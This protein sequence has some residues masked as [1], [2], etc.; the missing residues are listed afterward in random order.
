M[1]QINTYTVTYNYTENGGTAATKTSASVNYGSTIDLTPTA[2]KSGYTFVGW[3]TNKNGTSKLSSLTMGTSNVTLYAIYSKTVT[4]TCYYYSG[5]AQTSKKVSGTMYNKST[6]ASINLGTTTLTGYTFRG[7]STSNSGNAT[8]AVASN[9][10]ASLSADATYYACYSYTVTGTYKYYN[11]TA[12]TSSTA[13]ATAYMNSSG[14]K[15]G[16]KPTAPTVSNPSG[17]TARGWSKSSESNVESIIVPGTITENITYYYS[18]KKD[19]VG[20]YYYYNGSSFTTSTSTVTAYMS[21]TGSITGGKPTT[22]TVSNPSG[23]TARGWSKSTEANTSNIIT[24]GTITENATYYYS[25]RKDVVGTYYYYNGSSFTTST[26]TV[27][28]YMN[29]AGSITGGKPTAPTVSNPSGWTARGW[30]KSSEANASNIITPGTITENTTYYY[31]WK[32]DVV[33]TYYY[34]NGSS[35]TNSTST[36]NAYMSSIGT[37][38]GGKPTAPTVSNPSGWTARGWSKSTE[39]NTSSII[40][41][42]TIT[43]NATYYYSWKKTITVSYDANGGTGAPNSQTTTG[44][45]NYA[46]ASSVPT[47]ITISST[48]PTRT[49]Y[50]FNG[51]GTTPSSTSAS[52]NAGSKYSATTSITLYAIWNANIY[53]IQ[54]DNNVST[55]QVTFVALPQK[56]KMADK[57]VTG[58]IVKTVQV[59]EGGNA[60]APDILKTHTT[61]EG[62]TFDFKEWDKSFTNIQS[63]IVVNATYYFSGPTGGSSTY[64]VKTSDSIDSNYIYEKY[65]TGIYLDSDCTKKMT[66][67]ANGISIPIRADYIFAGYYTEKNGTGTKMLDENGYLTNNFSSSY[68]SNNGTLYAKWNK[69]TIAFGT[70]GNSTYAKTH[71]TKIVVTNASGSFTTLKYRWVSGTTKLTSLS[72]FSNASSFTNG[73]TVMISSG[74]GDYYLWVYAADDTGG[75]KIACSNVFKL[76][77]TNTS[78]S[79]SL[80]V[81]NKGWLENAIDTEKGFDMAGTVGESL[82]ARSI[83]AQLTNNIIPGG[84]SY[85]A[86]EQNY[87]WHDFTEYPNESGTSSSTNRI[88]AVQIKLTGEIANYYDIYYKCHVESV[89]WLG[90]AKNGENAGTES[91]SR[92]IEAMRIAIVRKGS[93]APSED[94]SLL[95]YYGA[96]SVEYS[97]YVNGNGWVSDTTYSNSI[98]NTTFAGTT[99]KSLETYQFKAEI[100]S[101]ASG[102]INY[103]LHQSDVG[104]GSWINS[105]TIAGTSGKRIEAMSLTLSGD[106]S[107]FFKVYYKAHSSN[108]GWLGWTHDGGYA[109][110]KGYSYSLQALRVQLVSNA[111]EAGPPAEDSSN[112][113][114][115]EYQASSGSSSSSHT[116]NFKARGTVL[117]SVPRWT[118]SH[119]HSNTTAY[120]VY[121]TECHQQPSSGKY[122]CPKAP[123]GTSDEWTILQ[124]M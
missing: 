66:S 118:C 1:W 64:T 9:G 55:H 90:W 95:A 36:A 72:D 19:V 88:E 13:T 32:K 93:A 22:P 77:N 52:Y 81:A 15:V 92:R 119:G 41:P 109:G 76:D 20:T 25:W 34:Y 80:Y 3:N 62:C 67:N 117:R 42:G 63:D 70:N 46:G 83:K 110:T 114:F 94:V 53:K 71:S 40:T 21:S 33:G 43:E 106:I 28:A 10:N 27:T 101:E 79:Y 86:H 123:Y 44:Y 120:Y 91:Q 89:G 111:D 102:N 6:T 14:T 85:K 84:I 78:V 99:G 7:W 65:N 4:A 30:S 59:A 31:S 2:T 54:L 56:S 58:V 112:A 61:E 26:S 73:E 104:W 11:G 38:T 24:P 115:Y 8:I 51:W 49:G 96:A 74:S 108:Y 23:W 29:S 100:N 116:H 82:P 5:T 16:G 39:A 97:L 12:Y 69:I 75:Y 57:E 17:W 50:T 37:I 121:C 103:K 98:S 113:A 35:Y 47:A 122:V 48:K 18:W 105:P 107:K 60:I 87:G 124:G 68:F 45:L